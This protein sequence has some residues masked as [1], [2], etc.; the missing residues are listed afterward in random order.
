MKR[1]IQVLIVSSLVMTGC[2]NTETKNIKEVAYNY[3]HAMAN[4]DI[5]AAEPYATNETKSTTFIMAKRLMELVGNEYIDSDTP[6]KIEI[7]KTEKKSDTSAYAVYHKTTP[8]KDFTDTLQLR[9]RNN[10]WLAHCPTTQRKVSP[11]N[12]STIIKNLK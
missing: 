7:I 6:A 11:S 12:D 8:I 3:S 9:K 10:K 5:E 2:Q 1:H 4:Y